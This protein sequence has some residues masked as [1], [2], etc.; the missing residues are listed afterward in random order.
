MDFLKKLFAKKSS[1]MAPYVPRSFNLLS[2]EY[3]ILSI[4]SIISNYERCAPLFTAVEKIAKSVGGLPVMLRNKQTKQREDN[5]PS[6]KLMRFPNVSYQK[7]ASEFF[8]TS[9]RWYILEGDLYWLI[10]YGSTGQ[11]MWTEVLNPR[12]I[13]ITPRFSD[14][15]EDRTLLFSYDN[16]QENFVYDIATGT[17]WSENGMKNRQ[18]VH[19]PNFNPRHGQQ[20]FEGMSEIQPLAG[21]ILTTMKVSRHTIGVLD[22]GLRPSGAFILKSPNGQV[23][24]FTK[25]Q[26]DQLKEEIDTKWAGSANSGRPLVIPADMDFKQMSMSA[27]DMDFEGLEKRCEHRIYSVL[28]VPEQLIAADKTTAGNMD[29]I[30]AEFYHSRILPLMSDL[31]EYYTL[32]ILSKFKNSADFE[33]IVD[34]EQVDVLIPVHKSRV[35]LIDQSTS[36]TI[37]EKRA[38][39]WSL[40]PTKGGDVITDPNGRHIAG[41]DAIVTTGASEGSNPQ[42]KPPVK[43]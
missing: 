17:Y 12:S 24:N 42:T 31:L 16:R 32:Y 15:A 14:F 21:E 29:N 25:E 27:K 41:P 38:R 3:D 26:R 39:A 19:V 20:C 13:Q 9:A 37:D 36:L 8:R 11:P 10:R 30:R 7:I 1:P 33:F 22:N 4:A 40:P 23:V 28:G 2:G 43:K 18:I 34:E 35:E 6:V 5:H